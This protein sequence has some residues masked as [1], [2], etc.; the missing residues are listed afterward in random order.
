MVGKRAVVIENG[1]DFDRFQGREPERPGQ[2]LLFVGSFHRLPDIMA[3]ASSL[4]VCGR[5][6][7]AIGFPK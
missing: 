2:R 5:Y 4:S 7:S 3:L 6:F 1:V